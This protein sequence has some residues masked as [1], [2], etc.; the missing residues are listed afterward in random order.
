MDSLTFLA[1]PDAAVCPNG[2]AQAAVGLV[3]RIY[4]G[5]RA[6]GCRVELSCV[7]GVA[8]DDCAYPRAVLGDYRRAGDARCPARQT[9]ASPRLD[10][11]GLGDGNRVGAAAGAHHRAGVGLAHHLCPD[12]RACRRRDGS[13]DEN[14]AAAGKQ[15]FRFAREPAAAGETSAP[16]RLIRAHHHDGN[17]A[18]HRIQLH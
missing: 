16:A 15:K 12:W 1:A 14:P 10:V 8:R 2:T 7:A 6:V 11:A 5:A 18:F 17:R 3:H 9:P 4:R 13:A